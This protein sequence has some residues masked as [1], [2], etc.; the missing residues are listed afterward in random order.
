VWT[1]VLA[2][3]TIALILGVMAWY[4]KQGDEEAA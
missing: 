1:Q 2:A 4:A 3:V